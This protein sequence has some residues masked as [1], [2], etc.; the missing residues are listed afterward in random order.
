MKTKI[1]ENQLESRLKTGK[2]I[3]AKRHEIRALAMQL[4]GMTATLEQDH[5]SIPGILDAVNLLENAERRL[6]TARTASAI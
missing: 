2:E 3:D 5:P 4:C 1:K 6:T